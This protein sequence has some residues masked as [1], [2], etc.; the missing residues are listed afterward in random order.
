MIDSWHIEYTKAIILMA[1]RLYKAWGTFT[2]SSNVEQG[3]ERTFRPGDHF[4][5]NEDQA[6]EIVVFEV[7]NHPFRVHR[8]QVKAIPATS[9]RA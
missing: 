2:A 3:R 1:R 5:F 7:D 4:W 9:Q 8:S 6:D